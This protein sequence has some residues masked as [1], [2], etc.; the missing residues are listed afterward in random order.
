MRILVLCGDYWHPK[1]GVVAGLTPIF[2]SEWH[3]DFTE[4]A[5]EITAEK[6]ADYDSVI[7]TKADEI[8]PDNYKVWKT[9]ENQAALV[10]YV[11]AG[12]GLLVLHAG[13]VSGEGTAVYDQLVGCRF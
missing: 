2:K 10:D 13:T 1:E 9:A 6:L 12:G 8:A 4:D 7:I 11:A 5:T 3:V